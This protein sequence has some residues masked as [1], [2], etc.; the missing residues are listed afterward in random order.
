MGAYLQQSY[1][2]QSSQ[3]Y[4]KDSIR[5]CIRCH[6]PLRMLCRFDSHTA[7]VSSKPATPPLN[8]HL[9]SILRITLYSELSKFQEI[10][11][12]KELAQGM[13]ENK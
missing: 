12:N 2:A 3:R 9:A 5:L 10:M 13:M 4:S 6:A 8:A 7:Q 1:K 11:V